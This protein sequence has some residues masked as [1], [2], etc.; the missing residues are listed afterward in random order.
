MLPPAELTALITR[1]LPDARVD[2]EDLTGTQDHYSI[3]VVSSAFQ[4][5]NRIAQQRM[6]FDALGDAMKG[7]IHALAIKTAL[8]DAR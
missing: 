2:V 8:P 4:G 5:K 3:T 7:P 6:I 1:A